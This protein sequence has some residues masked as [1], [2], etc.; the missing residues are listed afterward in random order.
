MKQR[1]VLK[2]LLVLLLAFCLVCQVGGMTAQATGTEEASVSYTRL[3]G[4]EVSADLRDP[5]QIA[6]KPETSTYSDTGT[7]RVSIVLDEPSTVEA[8]FETASI[9][10]NAAAAAYRQEL[11]RSQEAV[12]R[13]ISAALGGSLDVV[14]NLTLAANLIS[15]NVRYG[16]IDAIKE[17][18][19][20]KAVYVETVYEPQVLA[21]TSDTAYPTMVSAGQMTGTTAAWLEGYTGAGSRIAVIDT[22]LD[23][24]H[25]SFDA[26]AYH[27]ALE[28]NAAEKGLHTEEYLNSLH[29]LSTEEIAKV[30]PQLNISGKDDSLSADDLYRNEK[31]PFGYNYIDSS[32]EV[33]HDNDSAGGHGSHVAGIAT[34]NRYLTAAAGYSP[35]EDG[36]GVVGVAPDAQIL[37]MKVFG[38]AGGAY[39]SDYMAA[40]EDAIV[41]GCDAVNLSL[42]SP[43]TGF[44][45]SSEAYY[46]QL[47]ASL[48]ETDTVV[49]ISAGNNAGFATYSSSATGLLYAEDVNNSTLGAPGTMD[50]AFTVAS[51]DNLTVTGIYAKF[52]GNTGVC[53]TKTKDGYNQEWTTLDV[54]ED[55]SGTAYDYVFL[56][57]PTDPE[58]TVK[59]AVDAGAFDGLDV[60]GKIVLISRGTS[61]FADKH[62]FAAEAGAAGVII[63]NNEPGVL[64]AS[65]SGSMATTPCV[66]ISSGQ[67]QKVFAGAEKVAGIYGGTVTVG[68]GVYSEWQDADYYTLST[69]SSWGVTETLKLKPEITAP[70]GNIYSVNGEVAGTDQYK[71]L[72]GTSMAAPHVAGLSA[73]LIQY[74][75]ENGLEEKTGLSARQLAQS[76]LMSTAEPIIEESTDLEYSV[77]R[78]GAGL[79]NVSSAISSP[80]YV[81]VEGQEDGKVKIELGDDPSR[82]GT[83]SFRF[84]VE[85]LTDAEQQYTLDTSIMAPAAYEQDG[86][87]YMDNVMHALSPTVTWSVQDKDLPMDFNGDGVFDKADAQALMA[88]II[89]G[90]EIKNESK[91]DL[92][93]DGQI[94]EYDVY[95]LLQA[96][97]AARVSTL[98]VPANGAVTVNVTVALSQEDAAYIQKNFPNGTYVE[99]YFYLNAGKDE[100]GAVGVSHSIPML[101]FYGNW[102]DASMFD[103]GTAMEPAEDGVTYTGL[104]RVNYITVSHADEKLSN[105]F[106]G[107][108]YVREAEYLEERNALNTVNGD[109]FDTSVTSLIRNAAAIR[110]DWYLEGE[111]PNEIASQEMLPAAFYYDVA[112][113]WYYTSYEVG[114][115]EFTQPFE[116]KYSGQDLEWMLKVTAA[117][118]Y[119]LREDGS[120]AWDELGA[121]S[122]WSVR[123]TPDNE[124][125]EIQD[126]HLN[127]D[128]TTGKR[129]LRVTVKDNRYTAALV[130]FDRETGRIKQSEPVNQTELGGPVTVELDITALQGSNLTIAACDYACNET[131]YAL[132]FAGFQPEERPYFHLY[133]M[134]DESW[135]GVS[136]GDLVQE[137]V[138]DHTAEFGRT[139]T[140]TAAEYVDGY[141]FYNIS[142]AGMP[143]E[144]SKL[145][146]R[147]ENDFHNLTLIRDLDRYYYDFA[148]N[149]DDGKLYGLS[150]GRPGSPMPFFT[151]SLYTID[152]ETGEETLVAGLN[153]N[154]VTLACD[155]F[156]RFYGMTPF[157][158]NLYTFTMDDLSEASIRATDL[159]ALGGE[160]G[161]YAY[162]Q[163]MAWD[164]NEG[165]LYW[166]QYK[167]NFNPGSLEANADANLVEVNLEDLTWTKVAPLY[168]YEPT[169][170]YIISEKGGR[171]DPTLQ[172]NGVELSSSELTLSV[173]AAEQLT[174]AVFPW[175]ATDRTVT[176]TS[177]DP[178]IAT[179]ASDGTVT[180]VAEGE[181]RITAVSNLD[182]T[183]S[184]SCAVTVTP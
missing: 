130:I 33:T 136:E 128:L 44:S 14:W 7:V 29:L 63:Y 96:L 116:D 132:E 108:P 124:A 144:G 4:N 43:N 163:T 111:G 76:L 114:I 127:V 23:T 181:C 126:M 158:N 90:Q 148:Y 140:V 30:L 129:T 82:A 8:G 65:L 28:Q 73:V 27:Y 184:A 120:V 102:S 5:A 68:D 78:Q 18:D 137:G 1:N 15:A 21:G 87:T 134:Y 170:L 41:L 42:G 113:T 138:T 106:G 61:S 142:T 36:A 71:S 168:G 9:A 13:D 110:M 152:L 39:E 151:S 69:F 139:P 37:T 34:A 77:R 135:V 56:G 121:G 81:Q 105:Y 86:A 115:Q 117:P 64:N 66:T 175:N 58:D 171:F 123:F 80:T 75:R 16:E 99:G 24:D 95:L 177:S 157:Y 165:K 149:Y 155:D 141:V 92:S 10:S 147:K 59:Y 112:G 25:Q 98:M 169:G 146:V 3:G 74:I 40:I 17:I 159:G 125:P 100:D 145:Y 94:N 150:G 153:A 35:A 164:H 156:G 174:A 11:A 97:Q 47:F 143:P 133:S 48:K 67:M 70:G 101:A 183:V 107:N 55:Q 93:G 178:G 162:I 31:I 154:I 50:N 91:A 104:K 173:G 182:N 62:T 53:V 6:D 45:H 72:S 167:E 131:Y 119:Y 54:S 38:Q 83:Y 52:N 172:V 89:N 20:V 57:D 161:G 26:G 85:N 103:R 180:A 2:R 176:W 19:G 109:R 22:G 32:L 179:V 88:H 84:T 166:A 60:E 122:S 49:S 79:A 12:E 46:N 118:E 51:V 160:E